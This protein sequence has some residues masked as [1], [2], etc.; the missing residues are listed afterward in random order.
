MKLSSITLG[1]ISS[2]CLGTALALTAAS[3]AAGP[4]S[5]WDSSWTK[6]AADDTVGAGGF[7]DPGWGGQAFDAEYLYYKWD[8]PVLS[9]GLQSGF[10]LTTGHVATGGKDYYAGD[11]ALSFDG[12]ASNYEYAVDFGLFTADYGGK[13]V[14]ATSDDPTDTGIDGAGLYSVSQWNTNVAFPQ[15]NPFAMD[16]GTLVRSLTQNFSG[17]EIVGGDRSFYR[18]VSIDLSGLNI[19]SNVAMHWTMSCGNDVIEGIT[20]ST[21]KVPEPGTLALLS[22]GLLGLGIVRRRRRA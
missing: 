11:L 13:K 14:D 15:S 5:Q 1:S 4:V 9:I 17:D 7:V 19:S 18:V 10:D 6:M 12:N 16:L 21:V 20:R 2:L 3:A 8:G 22:T